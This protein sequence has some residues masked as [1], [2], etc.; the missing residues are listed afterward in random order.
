MARDLHNSVELAAIRPVMQSTD[1]RHPLTMALVMAG[2]VGLGVLGLR[3]GGIA[4]GYVVLGWPASGLALAATLALGRSIWPAISAGAFVVL[5]ASSGSVAWSLIAA[6]GLT[7]EPIVGSLLVERF[8]GGSNVFRRSETVFRFVAIVALAGAPVGAASVVAA[9]ILLGP[10][11]WGDI[12]YFSMAWWLANLAG[13]IVITPV[14][15]LWSTTRLTRVHPWSVIEAIVILAA[16]TAVSLVVF[17]GQFPADVQNYPLEF[18]CV[19]FLLW[20]AL[21]QGRRTVALSALI[22]CGVAA[23]GTMRGYGPFVRDSLPEAMVLVQA[24]ITVMATM[25]AVI[26]AVVSEHRAAEEQLRELATTDS[27]TGLANYRRLLDV[28]R[29]EIARSNRTARPFAVLFLDMDGLKRINDEHGHLAGSRALCR[30]ADTLKASCRA[31]DTPTR[32]GGDEFAIVLPE[33]PEEGGYVVLSRISE[34]LTAEMSMPPISVSGGVAVFPRDGS[35]PTQLL[36]SADKLLYES[37]TRAAA[38]RRRQLAD[39][40]LRTGTLT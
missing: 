19:P 22:L 6:V 3:I 2:Y 13:V 15:L 8:A 11:G 37:K 31:I 25:S 9:T 28:L 20:A 39:E 26:A 33:T 38:L 29:S 5:L 12:G 36:R 30:L 23:W 10:V 24:Y 14:V 35:S 27:L 32:F 1:S 34:R 21:R 17:A 4:E 18:L 7:L 40:N 16:L